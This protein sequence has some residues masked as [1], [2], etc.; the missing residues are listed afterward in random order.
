MT[1]P[2]PRYHGDTG[3][4]TA[5]YRRPDAAPGADLPERQ[6]GPLPGDRRVDQRELRA[7]PLG[8]GTRAQRPCGALPPVDL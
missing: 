5:T 2:P 6:H 3:E 4:L 8:D 1:Y 7:L